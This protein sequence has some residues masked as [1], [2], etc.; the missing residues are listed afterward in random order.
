MSGNIRQLKYGQWLVRVEA[1]RDPVTGRRIQKSKTV[2][3]SKRDAKK[4]LQDLQAEVARTPIPSSTMSLNDL[5][6]KW[7][8]SPTKSGR[9]RQPTSV[10]NTRHRY[11]RY[12]RPLIGS[13]RICDLKRGDVCGLYD[14]LSVQNLSPR[15][16]HHVHSELRSMLN[17]AWRR[18]LV[19]ENVVLRAE[20]PSVP[21]GEIVAPEREVVQAHLEILQYSDPDLELALVLSAT[22]GLRR[23]E[24][25]G[26]RWGHV[27]LDKGILRL[28]E[29]ITHVPGTGFTTTTTKTGVHGQ[30]DYELHELHLDRLRLQRQKLEDRARESSVQLTENPYVFS[31]DPFHAVPIR[32]DSLGQKLRRHCHAHPDLPV[33]T[34]KMLR[35]YTSSEVYGTGA[36]ETTAA[37][38]L[39]DRPETTARHYRAARRSS[40]RSATHLIAENLLLKNS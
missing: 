18:E 40:L 7:I 35:T 9:P 21:L 36:D 38:I 6:E 23:S 1:G 28:R 4:C 5:C 10:Y 15:T 30:A 13:M 20:A 39:R 22:L 31:S 16:I 32:P 19:A 26:L 8:E 34:L 24:L 27:D 2:S 37:A 14:Q 11:D 3:G 12:V 17:W 29:G 25:A 33:L